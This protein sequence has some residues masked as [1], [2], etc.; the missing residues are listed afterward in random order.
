MA[1]YAGFTQK[2]WV[3]TCFF[4]F[5]QPMENMPQYGQWVGQAP[6]VAGLMLML[7]F[8]AEQKEALLI[9]VVQVGIDTWGAVRGGHPGWDGHGGHGS[10]KKFPIVFAGLLLGDEEGRVWW[11]ACLQTEPLRFADPVQGG[12]EDPAEGRHHPAAAGDLPVEDVQKAGQQ[13]THRTEAR[14][15]QAE[16]RPG[17]DDDDG[18]HR[19]DRVGAHAH[20]DE[21]LGDR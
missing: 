7:D 6:S 12:I 8:P 10:G 1:Q 20:P 11:V 13:Q 3:G 15:V 18:A 17:A 19:S 2:P 9:G 16:G 4:T 21:P 5:E 14:L